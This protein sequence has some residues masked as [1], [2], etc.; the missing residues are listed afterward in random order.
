MRSCKLDYQIINPNIK[1]MVGTKFIQPITYWYE[2]GWDISIDAEYVYE[3]LGTPEN[4]RYVVTRL[5]AIK[6]TQIQPMTYDGKLCRC[7]DC[8]KIH[9]KNKKAKFKE[10]IISEFE[11]TGTTG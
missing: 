5:R 3:I 4:A 8:L 10:I 2:P 11:R 9:G 1:E 7:E 6:R